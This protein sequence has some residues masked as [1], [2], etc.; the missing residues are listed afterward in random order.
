MENWKG[1]IMSH[2]LADLND[3]LF[4]QLGRL[5]EITLSADEIE[6]EVNR[7]KALV[8]V[9]DKIT[10]NADLQLKAA[11]LFAEHGQAVVSRL[12]IIGGSK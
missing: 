4:A 1:N 6:Q 2:T 10:G 5:S 11:K 7:T 8:S 3:H 12:P 9:A